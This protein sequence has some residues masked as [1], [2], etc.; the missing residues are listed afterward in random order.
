MSYGVLR[1]GF[2]SLR[3]NLMFTHQFPKCAPMFLGSSRGFGD[4]SIGSTKKLQDI[5]A[6]ELS[7]RVRLEGLKSLIAVAG[8]RHRQLNVVGS[9]SRLIAEDHSPLNHVL[10]FSYV[11]RPIVKHELSHCR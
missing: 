7:N 9:E 2:R 1:A 3:C 4:I 6:L 11:A 10:Q 8:S 5:G